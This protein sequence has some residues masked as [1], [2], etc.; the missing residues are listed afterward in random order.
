MIEWGIPIEL[1]DWRSRMSEQRVTRRQFL[2]Y[3]IMGVGGFMAA[4][5]VMP[6]LRMAV[7]PVLQVEAGAILLQQP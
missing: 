7:D 1:Q 3:T 2:S 5:S 6:M 4:A